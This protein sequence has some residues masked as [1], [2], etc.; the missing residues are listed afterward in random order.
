MKFI[1]EILHYAGYFILT[2]IKKLCF[3]T[4]QHQCSQFVMFMIHTLTIDAEPIHSDS[5]HFKYF[6]LLAR[7]SRKQFACQQASQLA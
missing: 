4:T 2:A 6:D 7:D 3:C 1:P 5:R